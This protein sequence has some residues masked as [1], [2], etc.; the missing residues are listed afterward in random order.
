MSS[1]KFLTPLDVKSHGH[2]V[3]KAKFYNRM[4]PVPIGEQ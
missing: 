3:L 2:S 1:A 4:E